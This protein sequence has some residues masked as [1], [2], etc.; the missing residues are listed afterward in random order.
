[1]R[2]VFHAEAAVARKGRTDETPGLAAEVPQATDD[3]GDEEEEAGHEDADEDP[4]GCL[5]AGALADR[6]EL[7]E[8]GL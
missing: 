1:M 3:T 8:S 5:N 6:A 7:D 2:Q 4:V